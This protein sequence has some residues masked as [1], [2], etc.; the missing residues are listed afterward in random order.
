MVTISGDV[1]SKKDAVIKFLK[2]K[3]VSCTNYLFNSEDRTE[4]G[5]EHGQGLGRRHPLYGNY[6]TRRRDNLSSIGLDRAIGSE[7]SNSWL[8]GQ[9]LLLTPE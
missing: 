9:V 2:D 1:P 4:L 3:Q 6:Q 7:K 5:E 8:L